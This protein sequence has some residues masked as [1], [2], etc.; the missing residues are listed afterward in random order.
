MLRLQR[1]DKSRQLVEGTGEGG[2]TQ[3]WDYTKR[4][5]NKD[6]IYQ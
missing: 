1:K 3:K 4:L 5:I 6:F 2:V